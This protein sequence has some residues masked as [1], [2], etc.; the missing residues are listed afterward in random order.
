MSDATGGFSLYDGHRPDGYRSVFHRVGLG[1]KEMTYRVHRFDLRMTR[2][3]RKLEQFLNSL[4]G[5][6]TSIIPN[7]TPKFTPGGMGA[8]VDFLWIVEKVS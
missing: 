4:E 8:S 5:E 2:D 6:V 7:V 3:Q 1:G